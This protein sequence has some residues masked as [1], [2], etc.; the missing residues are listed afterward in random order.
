MDQ[1]VLLKIESLHAR[2]VQEAGLK[3]RQKRREFFTGSIAAH[4]DEKADPPAN[5]GLINL[6]TGAIH[7]RWAIIATLPVTAD[8]LAAGQVSQKE[9]G[10]LRVSFDEVGQ[11]LEDG[12]GFDA[13]GGG[14]IAPG[15]LLSSANLE[16][17][18]NLVRT[19][20]DAR[21]MVPLT[22]ALASG[23]SVRCAL[24]PE[25]YLD[26]TLPK[27]LG[28]GTQRLNLVGAFVLVPVMTLG[29]REGTKRTRR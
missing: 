14:Q 17:Q 21:K 24:I 3:L 20:P 26:L 12:A 16:S 2:V 23:K 18:H 5:L 27:S 9:S 25:S 22:R 29:G 19:I 28:G 8:A 7:L 4:L 10:P 13:T 15:S 1:I 6:T 11:V